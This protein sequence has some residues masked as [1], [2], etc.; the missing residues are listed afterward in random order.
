MPPEVIQPR[1][2]NLVIASSS[3]K[4]REFIGRKIQQALSRAKEIVIGKHE[5]TNFAHALA[6]FAKKDRI[7]TAAF[8]PD[9]D[10]GVPESTSRDS[11]EV[12]SDK[13]MILAIALGLVPD[14]TILA[15]N[16]WLKAKS[17]PWC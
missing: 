12:A 3:P 1:F 17:C 10:A 6:E 14:D 11:E 16:P 8:S 4:R 13:A 5:Q 2:E 9:V 15:Q 7:G